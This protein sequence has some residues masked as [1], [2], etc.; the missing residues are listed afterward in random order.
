MDAGAQTSW[1]LMGGK[2]EVGGVGTRGRVRVVVVMEEW[3][4]LA[5]VA[6][7]WVERATGRL[8]TAVA[9]VDQAV[10]E[11]EAP[12]VGWGGA[13]MEAEAKGV[14]AAEGSAA[15]SSGDCSSTRN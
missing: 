8:A 6:E 2:E 7:G 1:E 4:G 5:R 9:R 12:A 13:G 3:V 10:R 14:M 11:P 15:M